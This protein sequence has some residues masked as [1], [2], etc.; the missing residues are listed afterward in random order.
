MCDKRIEDELAEHHEKHG[1][2]SR[3]NGKHNQP[4]SQFITLDGLVVKIK[5]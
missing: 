5:L 3:H 1:L 4:I 2:G